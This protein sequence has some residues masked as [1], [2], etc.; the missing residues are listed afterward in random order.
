[1]PKK[2]LDDATVKFS[3]DYERGPAIFTGSIAKRGQPDARPQA[4]PARQALSE[5]ETAFFPD[6]PPTPAD[7]LGTAYLWFNAVQHLEEDEAI[8]DARTLSYDPADWGD[9][10]EVAGRFDGWGLLQNLED[11]E[12]HPDI[13]YARILNVDTNGTMTQEHQID[14]ADLP[15]LV[16]V[17]GPGDTWW[18]VWGLSEGDYRPSASRVYHGVD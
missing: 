15:W 18:R 13:K 11:C 5:S 14:A 2:Y 8:E 9:Y 10:S 7:P 6:G 3:F 17:M 1:M 12:G 16:L 4:C